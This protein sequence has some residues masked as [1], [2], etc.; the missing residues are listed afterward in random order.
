MASEHIVRVGLLHKDKLYSCNFKVN[1]GTYRLYADGKFI[2]TLKKNQKV[3]FSFAEKVKL[4]LYD[5]TYYASDFKLKGMDYVN[6]FLLNTK[7]HKNQAYDDDLEISQKSNSLKLINEVNLENYVSAVVEGE[8][9]YRL[10]PEFYKLQA[11]LSRTYALKNINRHADEGFNVCDKVHC[12]V[13][14]HKC[15]K[16]DIYETTI[17]TNSL[18]V[19][20]DALNLINTIFHSNC[21]GQTCN[22]EDVWNQ[23]LSYLRC[24]QDSFCLRSSSAL[25]EKAIPKST[26]HSYFGRYNVEEKVHDDMFTLC[27]VDKRDDSNS[28]LSVPLTKVRRDL[29][30][31]STYFYIEEKGDS[32]VLYGRGYGHGVGLCQQGGMEM[33]S[34]GYGYVDILKHYYQGIHIINRKALKFF[35]E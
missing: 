34:R 22:S 3:R 26:L 5:S 33:A 14:H 4:Q 11:I 20:D 6:H 16:D 15:T 31:R 25:W 29:K 2:T 17:A 7:Y 23:K 30:L 24:V 18:V 10:P 9:G 32:V 8:A 27:Q 28:F 1:R 13:Y 35:Q 12:Q 21:G 19:V